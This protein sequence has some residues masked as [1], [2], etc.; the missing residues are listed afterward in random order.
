[1]TVSV[2]HLSTIG[3]LRRGKLVRDDGPD[4]DTHEQRVA[5]A[6]PCVDQPIGDLQKLRRA[7]HFLRGVERIR[8]KHAQVYGWMQLFHQRLSRTAHISECLHVAVCL[9]VCAASDG[10]A[11][12][13]LCC[14]RSQQ[15]VTP[16]Q[17]RQLHE[18]LQATINLAHRDIWWMDVVGKV[19]HVAGRLAE[20]GSDCIMMMHAQNMTHLAK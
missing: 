3:I 14:P 12:I 11:R 5:I 2:A 16:L 15:G 8:V 13:M 6:P 7:Q 18:H 9:P 4:R 1:M 19:H 10:F 17:L 20:C